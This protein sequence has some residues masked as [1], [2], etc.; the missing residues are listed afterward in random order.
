M[1]RP[2][3][4]PA[5]AAGHGRSAPVSGRYAAG[6]LLAVLLVLLLAL[7]VLPLIL[8]II[9]VIRLRGRAEARAARRDAEAASGRSGMPAHVTP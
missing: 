8:L 5:R 4:R 3:P 9:V 6:Q 2:D 1:P 7:P